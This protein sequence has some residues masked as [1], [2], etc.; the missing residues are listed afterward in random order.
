MKYEARLGVPVGANCRERVLKWWYQISAPI[1]EI[2]SS[3]RSVRAVTSPRTSERVT[4]YRDTILIL[5]HI[6]SDGSLQLAPPFWNGHRVKGARM[7]RG[8]GSCCSERLCCVGENDGEERKV[9]R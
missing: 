4:T 7:T 1:H 8:N 6:L 3:Q 5:L 9:D 2:E